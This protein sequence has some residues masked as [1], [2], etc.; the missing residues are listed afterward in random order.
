MRKILEISQAEG[1][2]D[3]R[4]FAHDL[5]NAYRKLCERMG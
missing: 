2:E 4:L 1:G 5:F 3:S